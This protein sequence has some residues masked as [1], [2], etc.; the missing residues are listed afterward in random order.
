MAATMAFLVC[1]ENAAFQSYSK[2]SMKAKMKAKVASSMTTLYLEAQA[3]AR[4][5][6]LLASF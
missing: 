4:H 6:T 2:S 1:V 5:I 3:S